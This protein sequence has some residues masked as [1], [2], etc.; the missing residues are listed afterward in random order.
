MM[1]GARRILALPSN[2]RSVVLRNKF[3]AGSSWPANGLLAGHS[4]VSRSV[5]T[6]AHTVPEDSQQLAVFG[7]DSKQKQH[8]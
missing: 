5:S 8:C 7:V 1:F 4:T 3:S 6:P 2:A